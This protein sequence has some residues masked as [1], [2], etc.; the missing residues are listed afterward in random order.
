MNA[1]LPERIDATPTACLEIELEGGAVTVT[2]GAVPYP[3]PPSVTE[4]L[5]T[6]C[7]EVAID[8]V[9]AAPTPP[10]PV[11]DIVG[12]TVYPAPAFVIRIL[13]REVTPPLV[14]RTPTAVARSPTSPVGEELIP[15]MGVEVYPDPSLL[16]NISEIYP[17][18]TLP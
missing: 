12:A 18:V 1:T 8:A 6:P 2:T 16:M 3:T 4:N 5:I 14:V 15:I 7:P 13:S 9:A 17:E 10:P 11:I